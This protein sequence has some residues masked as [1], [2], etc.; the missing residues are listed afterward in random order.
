MSITE[1]VAAAAEACQAHHKLSSNGSVAISPCPPTLTSHL[2][3]VTLDT[4]ASRWPTKPAKDAG[5]KAR[6]VVSARHHH[7]TSRLATGKGRCALV[8]Y[9]DQTQSQQLC[10]PAAGKR[11]ASS[12][13]YAWVASPLARPP[14]CLSSPPVPQFP[15]SIHQVT[16]LHPAVTVRPPTAPARHSTHAT[17]RHG[18]QLRFAKHPARMQGGRQAGSTAQRTVARRT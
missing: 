10:Q 8:V 18:S 16:F 5:H 7:R 12:N 2:V 14:A 13:C 6:N 9:A 4:L 11:P 3:H 15:R 1:P 17:R